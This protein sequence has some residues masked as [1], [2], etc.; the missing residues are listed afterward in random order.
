[1]GP[2]DLSLAGVRASLT[3]LVAAALA[4]CAC[5]SGS[6]AVAPPTRATSTT[7]GGAHGPHQQIVRALSTAERSAVVARF[8]A[9]NGASWTVTVGAGGAPDDVDPIRGIIRRAKDERRPGA[10]VEITEA[11]A[12]SEAEAFVTANA[13]LLGVGR[14]DVAALDIAAGPARTTTYG[15]WVAHVRGRMPMRGYEGFEAIASEIDVLLYLGEDGKTRYFVNISRVHPHL[16][17]DTWP[18]LGPDDP[19]ACKDV[20]GRELFVA[21]DD[22][23]RPGLR[24][25]E[26]HRVAIG[27]VTAEDVRSV[28]L[29][30]HAS[31]GPRT[32]YVSYWLAYVVDVMKR[33]QLFRFVVDADTGDLLEDAVVPVLNADAVLVPQ[34]T[35]DAP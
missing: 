17:L 19:R 7:A 21:I 26:L 23:R 15:T 12:V 1:V 2:V 28:R 6:A 5:A 30:I 18:R 29:T 31:P 20:L 24:V 11:S 13:E 25:R 33:G 8:R 32:A 10:P 35:D 14:S 4:A 9:T 34:P 16:D 27:K 3:A 22:A